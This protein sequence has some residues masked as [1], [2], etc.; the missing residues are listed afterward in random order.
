MKP[1]PRV[2][3]IQIQADKHYKAT[4]LLIEGADSKVGYRNLPVSLSTKAHLTRTGQFCVL[5]LT[6]VRGWWGLS[7]LPVPELQQGQVG[8]A[9]GLS[10]FKTKTSF[11]SY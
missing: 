3:E 5:T 9:I 11:L 6:L 2:D 4:T 7:Y 1:A 10:Y 8:P